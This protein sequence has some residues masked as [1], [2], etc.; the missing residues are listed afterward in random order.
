VAAVAATAGPATALSIGL[1]VGGCGA[2]AVGGVLVRRQLARMRRVDPMRLS[3]TEVG[4]RAV[5]SAVTFLAVGIVLLVFHSPA[6][7]AAGGFC[8]GFGWTQVV[9]FSGLLAALPSTPSTP[10]AP[11]TPAAPPD[12]A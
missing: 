2:L 12:A 4:M 3:R 6:L 8:L 5:I 10:P 11:P 9:L 7:R 1:A